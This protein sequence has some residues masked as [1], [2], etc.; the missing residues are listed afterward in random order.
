MSV[1]LQIKEIDLSQVSKI[2]AIHLG[3]VTA[4]DMLIIKHGA[5]YDSSIPRNLDTNIMN[6]QIEEVIE[7]NKR[8]LKKSED[9]IALLQDFNS[10]KYNL[11]D[12][13]KR[14]IESTIKVI[15]NVQDMSRQSLKSAESLFEAMQALQGRDQEAFDLFE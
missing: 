11:P 8:L 1:Q 12:P 7:I 15:E 6:Q 5:Y 9:Q 14:A 13:M 3:V 10:S 2:N 4:Y